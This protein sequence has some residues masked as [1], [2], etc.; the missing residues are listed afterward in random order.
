MNFERMKPNGTSAK[1]LH[2]A[3][4]AILCGIPAVTL[5]AAWETTADP[6]ALYIALPVAG[7][8]LLA[9]RH[10]PKLPAKLSERSLLPMLTVLC[11]TV[12]TAW[13]LLVRVQPKS[14]YYT[15]FSIARQLAES[16][17]VESRSTPC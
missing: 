1:L 2:G 14:D 6:A 17:Q 15:F 12:K 13:V 5:Y 3:M 7:A 8:L 11:V 10:L 4:L 9:K 16:W